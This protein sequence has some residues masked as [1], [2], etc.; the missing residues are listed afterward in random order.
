MKTENHI[1]NLEP[2]NRSFV[3]W[4]GSEE[5]EPVGIR[6]IGTD[7]AEYMAVT[8]TFPWVGHLIKRFPGEP[9]QAQRELTLR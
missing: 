1:V 3:H 6:A 8:D 2:C 9:W 5:Y 7:G 4:L